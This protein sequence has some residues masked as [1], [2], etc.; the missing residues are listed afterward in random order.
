VPPWA[1][2]ARSD[3]HIERVFCSLPMSV[4]DEQMLAQ[5]DDIRRWHSASGPPTEQRWAAARVELAHICSGR[6]DL[7]TRHASQC[8][9]AAPGAGTPGSAKE[10]C[11]AGQIRARGSTSASSERL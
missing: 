9:R 2:S 3:T 11:I 4:P 6:G 10:P 8:H 5:I 1:G 7:L